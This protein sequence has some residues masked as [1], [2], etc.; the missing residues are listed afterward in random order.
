MSK[1]TGNLH[2][3]NADWRFV[4][5]TV[6][7]YFNQEINLA[8]NEAIDFWNEN[9]SLDSEAFLRKLNETFDQN[10]ITEYRKNLIKY[11]LVKAGGSKI[12]KPKKNSFEKYTNRTTYIDTADVKVDFDK[13][14]KTIY[15][16]TSEYDDFDKFMATNTFITEFVNMV[17]TI[18]WPSRTGPNKTIRGCTLVRIDSFGDQVIF[19]TSGPNPPVIDSAIP[20]E[21]IDA[22]NHIEAPAIKNIRLTSENPEDTY[23]PPPEP[24]PVFEEI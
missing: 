22:P 13:Q 20:S 24:A 3:T 11:S 12:Y 23:Q 6:L 16:E 17:N 19:Y 8:Y 7:N 5:N 1:I 4:Y 9:N 18:N 14:N 10:E 15:I 21:V 2:L